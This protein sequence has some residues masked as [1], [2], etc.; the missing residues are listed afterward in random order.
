VIGYAGRIDTPSAL[1]LQP[2]RCEDPA[3]LQLLSWPP[4]SPPEPIPPALF[5]EHDDLVDEP[6]R[7][8][9]P[10]PD[11]LADTVGATTLSAAIALTYALVRLGEAEPARALGQDTLRRCRRVLGPE[12][13]G[14]L[15]LTH[16][17]T[18]D[19]RMGATLRPTARI[20]RCERVPRN[21]CGSSWDSTPRAAD[22][23]SFRRRAPFRSCL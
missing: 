12:H 11:A 4:S 18:I 19:P 1:S 5:R 3:A 8:I 20:V 10:G 21:S 13:P 22:L 15:H 14:V 9:A 17:T 2:L 23:E 6:L 16:A 7:S